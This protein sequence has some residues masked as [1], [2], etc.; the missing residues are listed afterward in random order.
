MQRTEKLELHYWKIRGLVECVKTFLEYV[1]IDYNIN[2]KV[3]FASM[4]IEKQQLVND[5]FLFANLPYVKDGDFYL[6]ETV[7]ILYYVAQKAKRPDL[8]FAPDELVKFTELWGVVLDYKSM[9]TSIC[10]SAKDLEDF[11][12]KLQITKDRVSSKISAL[13]NILKN[14]DYV[15]NRLTVIDFYLA[16]LVDMIFTMQK[17]TK[18]DVFGDYNEVYNSYIKR[19]YEIEEVRNYRNSDRFF[20]RPFNAPSAIWK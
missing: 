6:S 15:F 17:E 14:Q 4:M 11:K 20:E 7:A 10:Y 8:V 1:H 9:V 5:G 2:Y 13:G 3:D 16:E 12:A 19:F 18:V